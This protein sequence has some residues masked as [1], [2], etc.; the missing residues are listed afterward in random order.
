MDAEKAWSRREVRTLGIIKR[1][2]FVSLFACP[3][4]VPEQKQLLGEMLSPK[5]RGLCCQTGSG[6]PA[7]RR[8]R[9]KTPMKRAGDSLAG[10]NAVKTILAQL[11]AVLR[12]RGHQGGECRAWQAS[13]Y[14]NVNRGATNRSYLWST[15][16]CK[17]KGNRI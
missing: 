10:E 14:H 1:G 6:I 5:S 15:R 2:S 7:P 4:F 17:I 8:S 12:W 16:A 3:I 13:E 11:A 9:R